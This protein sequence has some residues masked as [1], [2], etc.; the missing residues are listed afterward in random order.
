MERQTSG[1]NLQQYYEFAPQKKT[2]KK[3]NILMTH[4]YRNSSAELQTLGQ[5]SKLCIICIIVTMFSQ[6]QNISMS[7]KAKFCSHVTDLKL[8]KEKQCM[9]LLTHSSI[10]LSAQ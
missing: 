8:I 9:E 6:S 3:L 1:Q 7:G 2:N 5:V 10:R 4:D